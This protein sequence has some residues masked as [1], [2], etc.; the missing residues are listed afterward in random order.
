MAC[1]ACALV[2][3]I[4]YLQTCS[5]PILPVLQQLY[6]PTAARDYGRENIVKTHDGK[7]FE[8]PSRVEEKAAS[9]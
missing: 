4:H 3:V 2:A 9:A 7:E 6:G 1:T 8:V 5:P